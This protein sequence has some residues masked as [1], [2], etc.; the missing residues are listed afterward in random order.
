MSTQ[1]LL[2][3]QARAAL[4]A[5]DYNVGRQLAR[6][7]AL[8]EPQCSKAWNLLSL[9]S[10][11]KAEYRLAKLHSKR[12]VQSA[13]LYDPRLVMNLGRILHLNNQK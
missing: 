2:L 12:S 4:E 13:V 9:F 6:R 7:Y 11:H 8:A 1:A 3:D 5:R 10:V